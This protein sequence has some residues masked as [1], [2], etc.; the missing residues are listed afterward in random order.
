MDGRGVRITYM[1]A[2]DGVRGLA[3]AG[4]M[5]Y[6]GGTGWAR[7]GFLGVDAFFVLSGYLITTLLLAEREGD[8]GIDLRAFWLRRARRLLPA[9]FVFLGGVAAYAGF[10]AQPH[11]LPD[12]RTDAFAT[13]AY[14]ANWQQV[15]SGDSYFGQ[16]GAPSP[17]LHTWSLAIEEQWYAVWPPVLAAALSVRAR[18]SAIFALCAGLALASATLM[19][20]LYAPGDD[21]S[22]IYYGMDTRAQSL[23]VGA[24]LAI[25]LRAPGFAE[26]LSRRRHMLQCAAIAAIVLLAWAW[27]DVTGESAILYRGGFLVLALCVATVIAAIACDEDGPVARVLGLW[28][29]RSLGVISYGAYLYHWPLFLALTPDR[30]GLDGHALFAIRCGATVAAA[31]ISYWVVEAPIRRGRITSRVPAR[32]AIPSVAAAAAAAVIAVTLATHGGANLPGAEPTGDAAAAPLAAQGTTRVLVVGDS[33]AFTLGRGL[34]RAAADAGVAVWNQGRLGCGLL[35]GDAVLVDGR[36][37]EIAPDCTDWGQRWRAYVEAFE[38]DVAVLLP[39]AWDLH[40]RE[41]GG[42]RLVFGTPEAE[43]FAISELEAA[44]DVLSSG[45]ARVM[46]VTMP[47]FRQPDLALSAAS[48][49]FDAGRIDAI[50]GIYARVAARHAGTVVLFDLAGSLR[51]VSARGMAD[52]ALSPDGVHFSDAGADTLARAMLPA[53]REAGAGRVR[54]PARAAQPVATGGP[55]TELLRL[56]PASTDSRALTVMHDYERFR[57]SRGIDP[58]AGDA[59]AEELMAYYRALRFDDVGAGTGLVP[60][61]V[62]GLDEVPPDLRR[63][64]AILGLPLG[65]VDQDAW[66]KDAAFQLL[67]GRASDAPA[68]PSQIASTGVRPASTGDSLA[69][70]TVFAEMARALERLPV[71]AVLVSADV[72]PFSVAAASDRLLAGATTDEQRRDTL[73]A[74]SPAD[75]LIPYLAYA[76]GAGIDERGPFTAVVLVHDTEVAALSNAARLGARVAGARSF[77]AG[78]PFSAFVQGST[79]EVDGTVLTAKLRVRAAGYWYAMHA[80]K[81]TLLLHE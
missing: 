6:H 29:L 47:A 27:H 21:L 9:L 30:T 33:V 14:V 32:F 41:A 62:T 20:L 80:V 8:G 39:G 46:L 72:A 54:E 50:N 7:G 16:F 11:E 44:A 76:T 56:V 81:D 18:R 4:V 51:T 25:A 71:Y 19:A 66:T 70:N 61:P 57:Q 12:I 40:D 42:R 43:A 73:A 28:P 68:S 59:T 1:P 22:R 36:W 13:L 37:T 2:L 53:I 58:P 34:E 55:W 64:A 35:R 45:G 78:Q 65:R 67:L 24:A 48:P 69:G 60:A 52:R 77:A 15:L 3:V 79:V 17:L 74:V 38:P 75:A 5:A 31:A 63:A 23:L 26:A 49:R 10:L